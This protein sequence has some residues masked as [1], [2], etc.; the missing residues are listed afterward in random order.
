MAT[1]GWG[2]DSPVIDWLGDEGYAF[3]F[4]QAVRLL[5]IAYPQK[6]GVGETSDPEHEVVR[7]HS[8]V[9]LAFPA[10]DIEQVQL[11]ERSEE[12]AE[13]IVN[14]LGLAGSSGP[15]PLAYTELLIERLWHKDT[16]LRDFLDIFNHRL[17]S[18]MYRTRK[19]H[20]IGLD[21]RSPE[22]SAFARFLFSI[23]GLG[24]PG[25]RGRLDVKDRALLHYAGILSHQPR[26]MS[27]LEIFLGDHFGV[28]VHGHQLRGRWLHLADD[29][30]T[31]IGLD[32]RNQRLGES[33]VLGSRFWEQ[34]G[35]FDLHLGPM[36]YDRFLEFLPSGP[37]FTSLCTLTRFYAGEELE[38]SF[39]LRLEPEAVPQLTLSR[40]EG[41]RLGWTSW[42]K[43][44][45]SSGGEFQIGLSAVRAN[46]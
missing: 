9:S 13:V 43:S 29:Q 27:G 22:R 24:T 26:S 40:S 12:Q 23:I 31:R 33:V 3:D 46:P 8:A 18:L 36:S 20:R 1:H 39:V 14:F 37:A 5:E 35:K 2:K 6:R 4:Y 34:N 38:F 41:S 21:V 17:V 28:P 7:F 44:G 15:L 25:L 16:A 19:I 42:L 10:S 30:L 45:K 11:P 32:G